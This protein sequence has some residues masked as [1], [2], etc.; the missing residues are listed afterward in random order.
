MRNY[1]LGYREKWM[2]HVLYL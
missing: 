1:P 2:P